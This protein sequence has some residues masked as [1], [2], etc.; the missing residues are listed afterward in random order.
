MFGVTVCYLLWLG[1]SSIFFVSDGGSLAVDLGDY[2]LFVF[3]GYAALTNIVLFS[4]ITGTRSKYAVIAGVRILIVSLSADVCFLVVW[5]LVA[6][7][8]GAYGLDEIGESNTLF[9]PSCI[10][11]PLALCLF[12][13][14]LFEAKRAPFDH[15]EAESELVAGHLVEFGGRA[16]LL[17]YICEY[18]HVLFSVYMLCYFVLGG[19]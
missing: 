5:G 15:A 4:I 1:L 19:V 10:L 2:S 14:T 7:H 13:Y 8:A 11:P 12:L 3:F 9:T 6:A 18:I 17:M 16:L